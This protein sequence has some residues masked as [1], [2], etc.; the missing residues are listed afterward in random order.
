MLDAPARRARRRSRPTAASSSSAR[1]GCT[2]TSAATSRTSSTR[3]GCGPTRSTRGADD[4]ARHGPALRAG[5]ARG[6]PAGVGG[7]GRRR[8]A[9]ASSGSLAGRRSPPDEVMVVA[10]YNAQ[11]TRCASALPAGVRVGT[12]DKFQG[13][14]AGRLLLDGELER[15]GRAARPRVP[16][17]AEPAERRGLARAV[18]RVPRREPAA[19]RGGLPDDRADAARERA[20][21][22]RRAGRRALARLGRDGL[23]TSCHRVGTKRD[24]SSASIEA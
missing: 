18:P 5:R 6:Q 20:L 22:V 7:G 11:V 4:A 9:R 15:R 13:Q 16:A 10:P 2:R 14:E 8:C 3:G 23:W 24:A 1:A 17:L 21:P 12:V 19:A